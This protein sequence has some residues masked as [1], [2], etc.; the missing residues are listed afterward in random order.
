MTY[1]RGEL[2]IKFVLC[3]FL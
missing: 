2:D 1:G 3:S